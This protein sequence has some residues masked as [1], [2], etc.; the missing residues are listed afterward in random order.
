MYRTK[1]MT[2]QV[3]A[4]MRHDLLVW[5][6]QR[7]LANLESAER[8]AGLRVEREAEG[9]LVMEKI[10]EENRQKAIAEEVRRRAQAN[11]NLEEDLRRQFFTANDQASQHNWLMA[12]DEIM[13]NYFISR[14]NSEKSRDEVEREKYDGY[15]M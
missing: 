14:M 11:K 8:E 15:R 2:P 10:L 4:D 3:E 5:N 12:K 13:K 9:K 1:D 7:H 6:S